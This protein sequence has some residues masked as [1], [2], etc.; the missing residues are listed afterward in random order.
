MIT[1]EIIEEDIKS[2]RE[3]EKAYRDTALRNHKCMGF[4]SEDKDF[5]G[6]LG[7]A[8][9]SHFYH[10]KVNL[11]PLAKGDKYDFKI[12]DKKIDVKTSALKYGTVDKLSPK[13]RFLVATFQ[14]SRKID[15]YVNIILS[16]DMKV[17]YIMGLIDKESVKKCGIKTH[18]SQGNP[19]P[20]PAYAV[21]LK[22]LVPI[23]K[24]METIRCIQ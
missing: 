23:E 9:F 15:Y 11:C 12:D 7:E 5:K 3:I 16:S 2:A 22:R 13:W 19:L 17:A 8:V 24:L 14:I 18:D 20:Y 1:I 6:G 4:C 21:P 10:L